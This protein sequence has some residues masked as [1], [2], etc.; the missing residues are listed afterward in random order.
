MASRMSIYGENSTFQKAAE[1]KVF[2]GV[3]KFTI[4]RR[5]KHACCLFGKNGFDAYSLRS[6]LKLSVLWTKRV[7]MPSLIIGEWST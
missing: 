2:G 3:L 6:P 1:E 4:L 7:S 5:S